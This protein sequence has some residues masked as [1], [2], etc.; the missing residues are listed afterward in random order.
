MTGARKTLKVFWVSAYARRF[1]VRLPPWPPLGGTF[2][3][4]CKRCPK[5]VLW[6]W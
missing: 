5:A 4:I 1:W 6:D 2:A 3:T